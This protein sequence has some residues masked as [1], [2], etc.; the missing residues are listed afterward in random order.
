MGCYDTVNFACPKCGELIEEQSKAGNCEMAQ[1][2][3]AGVPIAIAYA[4]DN[5]RIFCGKCETEFVM[6]SQARKFVRVTL[7]P[8][9]EESDDD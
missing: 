9:G 3:S 1:H 2:T 5:E 6:R 4:L 8:V 7:E